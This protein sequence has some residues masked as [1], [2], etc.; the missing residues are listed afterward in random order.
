[1]SPWKKLPAAAPQNLKFWLD[2][3]IIKWLRYYSW[4]YLWE[5]RQFGKNFIINYKITI[6]NYFIFF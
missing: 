1:M 5:G 2:N 3:N 6:K 4:H